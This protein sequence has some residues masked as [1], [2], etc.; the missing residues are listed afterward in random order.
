[1]RLAGPDACPL[2]P[3]LLRLSPHRRRVRVLELEPVRRPPGPM[4]RSPPLRGDPLLAPSCR[5]PRPNSAGSTGAIW[6]PLSAH[7]L[8][9]DEA[10]PHLEVVGCAAIDD[11]R[12]SIFQWFDT[13]NLTEEGEEPLA[14][15]PE[16][17]LIPPAEIPKRAAKAPRKVLKAKPQRPPAIVLPQE[18]LP[19]SD[20]PET[21]TPGETEGQSARATSIRPR[22]PYPETPSSFEDRFCAKCWGLPG[23]TE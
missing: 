21:A 5:M 6:W 13:A 9:V 16:P 18:K 14:Y 20:A 4:T 17:R 1:M 7:H 15:A 19:I 8:A 23:K 11:L 22:T 2:K 12:V 10:G 3:I